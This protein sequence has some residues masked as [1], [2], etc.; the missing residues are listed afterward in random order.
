ML[1]V[2]EIRQHM[3]SPYGPKDWEPPECEG[4]SKIGLMDTRG[5]EQTD[6]IFHLEG[7]EFPHEVMLRAR[8]TCVPFDDPDTTF[9]FAIGEKAYSPLSFYGKSVLERDQRG[10]L[11]AAQYAQ[12]SLRMTGEGVLYTE[13]GQRSL[14]SSSHTAVAENQCLMTKSFLRQRGGGLFE[15]RTYVSSKNWIT[16]PAYGRGAFH[17]GVCLMPYGGYMQ[18]GRGIE[19]IDQMFASLEENGK[20]GWRLM[21]RSL[22]ELRTHN[23]VPPHGGSFRE[24]IYLFLDPLSPQDH[25]SFAGMIDAGYAR[26]SLVLGEN[27][28]QGYR[29]WRYVQSDPGSGFVDVYFKKETENERSQPWA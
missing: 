25:L 1:L 11:Y 2:K 6:T 21:V 26:V 12:V 23:I 24:S 18:E 14:G 20:G 9:S 22:Q 28:A 16:T 29:S 19:S 17:C 4:A 3:V 8:V 15:R 13:G 5:R 10:L 7:G 27:V